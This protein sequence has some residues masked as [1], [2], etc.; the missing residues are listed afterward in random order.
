M[1]VLVIG[2]LARKG[3]LA[4][5]VSHAA[6][7]INVRKNG[8]KTGQTDRETDGRTDGRTPD[9][10]TFRHGYGQ[11]NNDLHEADVV[12]GVGLPVLKN[13]EDNWSLDVLLVAQ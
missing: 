8:K 6:R 1:S 7:P 2:L 13:V 3:T 4:A 5:L 12:A 10:Y 9:N 11:L